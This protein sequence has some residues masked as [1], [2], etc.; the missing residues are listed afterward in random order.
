LIQEVS[1]R[2]Y[3]QYI[4]FKIALPL[5]EISSKSIYNFFSYPTD[6]QTGRSKNITSFFGEGNKQIVAHSLPIAI[7]SGLARLP[8]YKYHGFLVCIYLA[9]LQPCMDEQDC[10]LTQFMLPTTGN[11]FTVRP[12]NIRLKQFSILILFCITVVAKKTAVIHALY[13][14]K[15][16][17]ISIKL[18]VIG[19]IIGLIGAIVIISVSVTVALSCRYTYRRY[20]Y[21]FKT[22]VGSSGSCDNGVKSLDNYC[23]SD[24]C[25][26]YDYSG[27]CYKYKTHIGSFGS[28][29]GGVNSSDG[30]CYHGRP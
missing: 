27:S 3:N 20:C 5:R 14:R 17:G 24:S 11:S 25:S 22:Y 18:S 10:R 9:I 7:Y 16:G 19:V 21:R 6:R 23:Y 12:Q 30:Y 1:N 15:L 8:C 4:L 13:A 2:S 26:N 28:C 29:S